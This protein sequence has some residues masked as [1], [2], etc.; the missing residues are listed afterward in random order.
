MTPKFHTTSIER[1]W[2]KEAS[3]ARRQALYDAV[4]AEQKEM[5]SEEYQRILDANY[6]GAD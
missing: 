2:D 6:R 4:A 1:P 3:R 5:P